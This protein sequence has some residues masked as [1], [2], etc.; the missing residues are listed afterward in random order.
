MNLKEAKK[1]KVGA[2]VRESWCPQSKTQ[3]VVLAKKYVKEPHR[4]KILCQDKN[5]RYDITIHWLGPSRIV[6]YETDPENI[7]GGNPRVQVRQSWEIMLVS[8]VD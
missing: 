7:Q 8:H 3:G 5:E 4:A 2:I 6:P 1:L